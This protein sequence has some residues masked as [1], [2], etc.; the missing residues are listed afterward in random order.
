[1]PVCQLGAL[2]VFGRPRPTF[3]LRLPA[4]FF[5]PT[6]FVG[7]GP[8]YLAALPEALAEAQRARLLDF[9]LLRAIALSVRGPSAAD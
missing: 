3:E 7:F 8:A 6:D 1:M 4:M 5:G 2:P 9:E